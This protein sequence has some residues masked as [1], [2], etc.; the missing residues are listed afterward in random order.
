MVYVKGKLADGV[1]VV[2]NI[3]DNLFERCTICGKETPVDMYDYEPEDLLMVL[4]PS[5]SHFCS[6]E[7]YKE[8]CCQ[9]PEFTPTGTAVY[10]E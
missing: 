7:C 1:K 6:K 9:H 10:T 2:V 3:E 4:D 5:T 8:Y